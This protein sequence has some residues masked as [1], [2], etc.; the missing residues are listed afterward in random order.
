MNFDRVAESRGSSSFREGVWLFPLAFTLHVLEE[1][2]QFTAWAQRHASERFSRRDYVAIHTAGLTLS[3][4]AAGVIWRFPNTWTVF[5]FFAFASA[6]AAFFNG[7]LT[8][9]DCGFG[10]LLPWSLYRDYFLLAPFLF[11]DPAGFS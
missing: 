6:P 9:G 4:L 7:F 11:S 3:L 2:P 5:V 1:W 10:R 8:L